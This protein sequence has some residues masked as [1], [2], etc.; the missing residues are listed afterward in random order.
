MQEDFYSLDS[1][2]IK[3]VEPSLYVEGCIDW[4]YYEVFFDE[5]RT[6]PEAT[7]QPHQEK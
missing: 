4:K 5:P 2:G 7:A 3:D 6:Q 1:S